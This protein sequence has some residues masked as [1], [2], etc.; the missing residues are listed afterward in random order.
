MPSLTNTILLFSVLGNL[1]LFHFKFNEIETQLENIKNK[2][3]K[4]NKTF[5]KNK[6]MDNVKKNQYPYFPFFYF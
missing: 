4:L 6:S 5:W 1:T 3:D 2:I